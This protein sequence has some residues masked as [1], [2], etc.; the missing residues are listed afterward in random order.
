VFI[1]PSPLV[2]KHPRKGGKRVVNISQMATRDFILF[3]AIY[4][5]RLLKPTNV[6]QPPMQTTSKCFQ[7][8]NIPMVRGREGRQARIQDFVRGRGVGVTIRAT[9]SKTSKFFSNNQ[10]TLWHFSSVLN[11]YMF[12][13][14]KGRVEFNLVTKHPSNVEIY[15]GNTFTVLQLNRVKKTDNL[16]RTLWEGLTT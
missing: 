16:N 7:A 4:D 1:S 15:F 10:A 13:E 6:R 14:R 5:N 8:W 12:S 2:G 9:Y 3:R 11:M